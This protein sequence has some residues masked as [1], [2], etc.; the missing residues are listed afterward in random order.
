MT[1][2]GEPL[3]Y[4]LGKPKML[5]TLRCK[6]KTLVEKQWNFLTLSSSTSTV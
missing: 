6:D 3:W 1:G 4:L 5:N 2:D